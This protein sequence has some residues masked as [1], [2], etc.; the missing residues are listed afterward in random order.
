M[1]PANP[2]HRQSYIVNAS[3]EVLHDV[4]FGN[5]DPIPANHF[6]VNPGALFWTQ[7]PDP[8]S[9]AGGQALI[10]QRKKIEIHDQLNL[11]TV[12]QE[13]DFRFQSEAIEERQDIYHRE[14]PVEFHF[15]RYYKLGTPGATEPCKTLPKLEHL[16]KVDPVGRWM[17]VV[18]AYVFEDQSP[19]NIQAARDALTKVVDDLSPTGISFVRIDRKVYDTQLAATR[20]PAVQSF[21]QTQSLAGASGNGA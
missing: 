19:E 14:A 10:L 18:V 7:L 4:D 5:K 16:T 21:G 2:L 1:E 20:N 3:Y 6:D 11:P 8:V 9:I 15:T 12:L 13:N 17:L